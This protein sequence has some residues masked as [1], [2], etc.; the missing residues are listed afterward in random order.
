MQCP[1]P[2]RPGG[3]R[4][5]WQSLSVF[6]GE[7]A[8]INTTPVP[9]N[10]LQ[11]SLLNAQ[12]LSSIKHSPESSGVKH[13]SARRIAQDEWHRANGSRSEKRVS[14]QTRGGSVTMDDERCPIIWLYHL[15]TPE[16]T[17]APEG[18]TTFYLL[19][20]EEASGTRG[21]VRWAEW[22]GDDS[23]LTRTPKMVPKDAAGIASFGF[24]ELHENAKTFAGTYPRTFAH[25]YVV[26]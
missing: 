13:A 10:R 4:R 18:L 20:I 15:E 5:C 17:N 11:Y 1:D 25:D 6:D 14:G 12:V 24:S 22:G 16:R 8:Q 3:F 9:R 2:R 21:E 19:P 26:W 23:R 7:G